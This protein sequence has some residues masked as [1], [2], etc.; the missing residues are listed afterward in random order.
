LR[1]ASIVVLS[2]LVLPALLVLARSLPPTWS[3]AAG[4]APTKPEHAR[5]NR[6]DFRVVVDVGHTAQSPGAMSARG[7]PEYEFN[8]R[9]ARQIEQKL[10]EGGFARTLL[11]VTAGAAKASLYER[12]ARANALPADLF[13]SIHHDSVPYFFR[14]EW[15]YEGQKNGFSDRFKGHSLFVSDENPKYR[16]SLAFASLLGREL[17]ERGLQFTPHYT[18]PFMGFWQRKLVDSKFGV[19]R[20]DQLHV[21]R[22]TRMPAVLLEAGSIVNR[23]EEVLLAAPQ[24][25]AVIAAAVA[26]A[27]QQFCASRPPKRPKRRPTVVA[28]P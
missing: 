25:Q 20:Y 24:R 3:D 6:A 12:V 15:E 26:D 17:R 14:E 9:L 21:L 13:V 22:T 27:A 16:L 11:L 18:Q 1:R 10:I 8:L 2:L 7:V 19:Y 4:A 5:C 23:D 28:S